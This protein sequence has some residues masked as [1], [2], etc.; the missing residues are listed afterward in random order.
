MIYVYCGLNI[1][2]TSFIRVKCTDA[3]LW[4]IKDGNV[5]IPMKARTSLLI[6]GGVHPQIA[7]SQHLVPILI[8]HKNDDIIVLSCTNEHVLSTFGHLIYYKKF[9]PS[10][11]K[12]V[13]LNEDSTGIIYEG[14]FNEEGFLTEGWPFGFF[15]PDILD[16]SQFKDV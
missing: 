6:D 8:G 7:I 16:I 12:I 4:K 5:F 9:D 2:K 10:Q 1:H 11:L 3:T 14:T 13:L 15:L